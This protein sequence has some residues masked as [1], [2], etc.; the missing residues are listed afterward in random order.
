MDMDGKFHI[1]GN[2]GHMDL[3]LLNTPYH[4]QGYKNVCQ[5]YARYKKVFWHSEMEAFADQKLHHSSSVSLSL[6]LSVRV[7]VCVCQ[8]HR[9]IKS[10]C[11]LRRVYTLIRCLML[12][13]WVVDSLSHVALPR[14]HHWIDASRQIADTTR[15]LLYHLTDAAAAAAAAAARAV[16][17]T[18]YWCRS[19]STW[20]HQQ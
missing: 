16:A 19:R 12:A 11:Q 8:C 18:T 1:Q 17:L 2:P 7:C 5:S 20:L 14:L 3:A 4:R 6:S 13:D 15:I 10:G 9:V